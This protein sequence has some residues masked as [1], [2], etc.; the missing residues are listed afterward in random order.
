MCVN[1]TKVIFLVISTEARMKRKRVGEGTSVDERS[2]QRSVAKDNKAQV[3]IP[4]KYR[5]CVF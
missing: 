2:C 4:H 1:C 5:V 3:V